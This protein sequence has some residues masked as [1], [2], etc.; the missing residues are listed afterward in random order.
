MSN[1]EKNVENNFYIKNQLIQILEEWN[2]IYQLSLKQTNQSY[3]FILKKNGHNK[4]STKYQNC[5]RL[6]L[7]KNEP[8]YSIT[9]YKL[10]NFN[11]D[12]DK[13]NYE[14]MCSI[15]VNGNNE[16]ELILSDLKKLIKNKDKNIRFMPKFPL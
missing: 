7:S 6:I 1:K 2:S 4:F 9:F 8:K 12:I 11:S 14:N 5:I 15:K 3:I 13:T 10:S 16:P